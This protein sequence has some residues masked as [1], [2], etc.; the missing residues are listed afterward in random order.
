MSRTDVVVVGGGPAGLAAAIE[1]AQ[2][3]LSV[4][5]IDENTS[6]GGKVFRSDESD[7]ENNRVDPFEAKLKNRLFHALENVS[8]RIKVC[9]ASEV[10]NIEGNKKVYVYCN[11]IGEEPQK[12][13]H[14][15]KLIIAPGAIERAVPFDGWTLPGVFT[16]GGLNALVKK[17]V[18]PGHRILIAGSGPLPMVLIKNLIQAK[19][20]IR[21]IV[22]PTSIQTIAQNVIPILSCAGWHR[23]KQGLGVILRINKNAIPVFSSHILKNVSGQHNV[24]KATIAQ[25]DSNCKE[26]AGRETKISADAI[27]A[28]HGLMPSV[29]LTQLAGCEHRYD[30]IAGCWRVVCNSRLE[31]T[32]PGVFVAGDGARVKGYEAAVSEGKLAGMEAAY[33][34]GKVNKKDA[35]RRIGSFGNRLKK[36]AK[37]GKVVDRLFTP[38]PGLLE[39]VPDHT[40]VCR[41]EE[42][43]LGEIRK[44]VKQGAVSINDIKRRTRLAMGHCQGRFCGQA[45]NELFCRL[46]GE[47]R[48]FDYFTPRIPVRPVPFNV[49]AK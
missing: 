32:V 10:W 39:L 37:F 16:I 49:F 43:T 24:F 17:K 45:I 29:E 26:I 21:A 48:K 14:G 6:L 7:D 46:S 42:V 33:Q 34:L 41:C 15:K 20:M 22:T 9:I 31:T 30:K 36:M 25:I 2:R 12:I 3:N 5:L 19:V 38:D 47:L 4:V 27:A 28:G 35:D 40:I 23:I 18:I 13:F 8:E 44:A 11:H 1:A